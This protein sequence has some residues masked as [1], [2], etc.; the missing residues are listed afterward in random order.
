[1]VPCPFVQEGELCVPRDADDPGDATR[2][3]EPPDPVVPDA[4]D[5]AHHEAPSAGGRRLQEARRRESGLPDRD[6][7]PALPAEGKS[8]R[9]EEGWRE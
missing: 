4:P 5:A 3:S 7:H 6:P 1:M 9:W 8:D 2:V